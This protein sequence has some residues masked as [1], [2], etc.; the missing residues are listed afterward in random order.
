LLRNTAVLFLFLLSLAPSVSDLKGQERG[1]VRFGLIPE[2]G[3]ATVEITDLLSD[4]SL[5]DAVTSGLPLRIRLR[6][7]LWKDGFFDSQKGQY[8]WRATVLFDP[9]TR[10]FRIQTSDRA[11]AEVEVNTL[12]E[13]RDLLQL[14]LNMP[15]RPRESG[16]YYYSGGIEIETLSLSDL[17]ELKRWLK[18]DLVPVVAGEGDVEGALAKGAR[19][20]L[21]RMLGLPAKR[22]PLQSPK[23]H[24]EIGDE[25][26]GEPS[27]DSSPVSRSYS[28]AGR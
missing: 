14:T 23:F 3:E 8:E 18:G 9:L 7:E 6:I 21:V 1:P 17:E 24:V 12:E 22:F 19:R 2:T 28:T 4:E 5:V 27:S 16:D 13:A 25:G 26:E 10:R 11:G 15:L 20:V